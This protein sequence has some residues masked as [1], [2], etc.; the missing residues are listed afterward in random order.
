MTRKNAA[1]FSPDTAVAVSTTPAY[2]SGDAVGALL[3]FTGSL[4]KAASSGTIQSV[5]LTDTS[6][7]NANIDVIIFNANPSGSTITDN[8]AI[9]I[10]AADVGKIVARIPIAAA[11]YSSFSATSVAVVANQNIP[12]QLASEGVTLY[13]AMVTTSTPTYATTTALTLRLGIVQD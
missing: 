13:A 12:I 1:L 4:N 5:L 7:Q 3:T 9:N 11:N 8:A 10:V 6:K 2:S